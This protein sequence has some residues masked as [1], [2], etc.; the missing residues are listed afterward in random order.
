M[1]ELQLRVETDGAGTRD[2]AAELTEEHRVADLATAIARH[3]GVQLPAGHDPKLLSTRLGRQL[4][5]ASSVIDS[6]LVTGDLVQLRLAAVVTETPRIATEGGLYCDVVSGASSGTSVPLQPGRLTIGRD[7]SCDL[8]IDDPTVSKTHAALLIDSAGGVEVEPFGDVTNAVVVDGTP[9]GQRTSLPLDAVLELG[10]SALVVRRYEPEDGAERDQL[11]QIPFNRTPYRH[12]D[13]SPVEVR[14]PGRPPAPYEPRPL[15]VLAMVAPVIAGVAFALVL[16]RALFLIFALMAPIS[17][18]GSWLSE[19]RRGGATHRQQVETF[20]RRFHAWEQR[21]DEA[22]AIERKR[23][24]R[25]APD[26]VDLGR[27]AELRTADLWP[28]SRT[29]EGFLE[30]RLGLGDAPA[31]STTPAPQGVDDDPDQRIELAIEQRRHLPSVPITVDLGERGVL[32]LHGDPREVETSA[33]SLIVQAATLHSPDELILCGALHPRRTLNDWL[34]WLPHTRSVVSPLAGAHL[35]VGSE[36]ADDLLHRLLEVV[37]D[38]EGGEWP[39]LLVVLDELVGADSLLVSSLL[40][41]GPAVGVH[42][43]W[44]GTS[45][46]LVPRHASAVVECPASASG[47]RAT[48]WTT[49]PSEPTRELTLDRLSLDAAPQVARALAPVRDASSASAAASIPRVAPL[50]ETLGSLTLDADEVAQRWSQPRGYGL[51]API[52]VGAAGPLEIDLVEHGPHALIAGTSGAGK[53]ELLQSAIAALIANH[54]PTRL[55]L[56]FI[57]YKGGASSNVFQAAP[58]TVGYVTNL[59]ADLAMRA[60]ISLRAELDRRMRVMEGRAKDLEEMLEKHPDE[61]PPSLVIVVDEFA[62]LVK[63]IPDFVAG[64]VD[65]AQRGRSLGIHLILATQRPAGA[66]NDNILA[67]TN[68]RISLRVLDPADSSSILG[69]NEA[70]GIPGPLR[71]RGFARL[72][73]GGLVEF[74]SAYSGAPYTASGGVTP[75]AVTSFPGDGRVTVHPEPVADH[76]TAEARTHLEVLLDAVVDA[77]ARLG[78]QRGRRPWLEDLPDLLTL[79]EVLDGTFG[80]VPDLVPGRDVLA[81]VVDLPEEQAQ[82]PEV[83]DLEATGGLLVFGTGGSGKTTT[84]RTLLA[85][86]VGDATAAEVEVHVLDFSGRALEGLR[87][88]PHV[89]AVASGDDLEQTTRMLMHL[90]AEVGARQALLAEARAEDLTAHDRRSAG[91]P[92]GRLLL[93]VDG[94]ESFVRTFERSDLYPW[95]ELFTETVL[96]GRATGLHL[97]ATADR[98]V[99][100]PA[101]LSNAVTGRLILR[102]ADVD[103]LIDL[104]VPPAVARDA[105]LGDGRAL[106][107]DGS[108]IQIPVVGDDPSNYGQTTALEARARAAGRGLQARLPALP[109]AVALDELPPSHGDGP[110]SFPLGLAD[111]TMDAVR[112]DVRLQH[113]AVIGP[114]ESG[115]STALRTAARGL[116]TNGADLWVIADPESPLTLDRWEHLATRRDEHKALIDELLLSAESSG[117]RPI[118]VVDAVERVADEVGMTLEGLLRDDRVRVLAGADAGTLGGYVAGWANALKGTRRRLLLQP[119]ALD[120]PSLTTARIRLRPNQEF[121]PGRGIFVTGKDWHLVQVAQATAGGQVGVAPALPP[122]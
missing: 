67:N 81:G 111:L 15:M 20:E 33:S 72:G 86:T 34:K 93:V 105:R 117:E 85:S 65:I 91:A 11:G 87:D 118:L 35:A 47:Q 113:L 109:D 28:R 43:L 59:G 114:D 77:T 96:A 99:S 122:S 73:A 106:L 75:V 52:G 26:V 10:S 82:R 7:D 94:Y 21:Y 74:Q 64:M 66:V 16:G 55:N 69:S 24:H 39:R 27:R 2:L 78:H 70:A 116:R 61:A 8:A 41:A 120:L 97:L 54:P 40:E 108:T 112:C 63:E 1:I 104:G 115:R 32:A 51:R 100:V 83:I 12:P 17:M 38:R 121:P 92:L 57:D 89:A 50:L 68:L 5:P 107:A 98:R 110:L 56:L 44:I 19:R 6:G 84:L 14:G 25:A 23:R 102:T 79:D 103:G 80:E 4:D 101:A 49:T 48:L 22:L 46:Q 29:A 18:L 30:L 9:I 53:S 95:S 90:R 13:L 119:D 58:H 3:L 62:T 31:L 37:A 71:G 45:L 76:E 60:L 88:L 36:A 42:A